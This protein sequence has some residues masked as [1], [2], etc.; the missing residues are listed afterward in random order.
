MF[1]RPSQ[2]LPAAHAAGMHIPPHNTPII[3]M[4][5]IGWYDVDKG[6]DPNEYPHFQ[7][8]CNVQL[9]RS[10][11]HGEHWENARIVAGLPIRR[12]WQVDLKA[13]MREG[14]QYG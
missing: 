3:A 6:F 9:W 13:L 1:S 12:V 8:F 10:A 5:A 14:L 11:D 7:V 2:L 4:G